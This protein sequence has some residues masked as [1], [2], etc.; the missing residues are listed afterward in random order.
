MSKR[1]DKKAEK[2]LAEM[3]W[4]QKVT[5]KLKAHFVSLRAWVTFLSL[6]SLFVIIPWNL[7]NIYESIQNKYLYNP[8]VDLETILSIKENIL[9][10]RAKNNSEYLAD[11]VRFYAN[12]L[13][14]DED[15]LNS[16]TQPITKEGSYTHQGFSASL[17]INIDT[18]KNICGLIRVTCRNCNTKSYW[19]N[20][21]KDKYLESF[22]SMSLS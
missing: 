13:N 10:I 16:E 11:D 12:L 8:T 21:E 1:T 4:Y 14:Y 15:G 18:S 6:L 20:I 3:P 7:F 22:Y 19:V 2:K 9:T 17:Q 5:N